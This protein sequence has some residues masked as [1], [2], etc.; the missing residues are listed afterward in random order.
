MEEKTKMVAITDLCESTLGITPRR[1]RDLA[2]EGIVPVTE[3]GK[4]PFLPTVK[5]VIEYYRKRAEA[6]GSLSLTDERTRLTRLNADRRELQLQKERGDL[7]NCGVA[8]KLW[9]AVCLNIK[10][11]I[12]QIPSKLAPLAYGLKTPEIKAV[13]DQMVYEVLMEIA[14]PNLEQIARQMETRK[15]KPKAAGTVKRKPAAGRK[16][17]G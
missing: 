16:K 17:R 5:A 6:G 9:A 7:I 15:I 1:Y 10:T 3:K 8:V 12:E 2:K 13:A 11:K 14:N 4:V